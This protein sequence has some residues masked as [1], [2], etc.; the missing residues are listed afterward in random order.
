MQTYSKLLKQG[1][2]ISKLKLG[3]KTINLA[4]LGNINIKTAYLGSQLVIGNT[5]QYYNIKVDL[6]NIDYNLDKYREMRM[7]HENTEAIPFYVRDRFEIVNDTVYL[8]TY[9]LGSHNYILDAVSYDYIDPRGLDGINISKNLYGYNYNCY[10]NK[11][12]IGLYYTDQGR[13]Q[14]G[15]Y[16][17]NAIGF[18]IS[19]S[20]QTY[21]DD[22]ITLT[23][24]ELPMDSQKIR[25]SYTASTEYSITKMSDINQSFVKF[26]YVCEYAYSVDPKDMKPNE[27]SNVTI[28]SMPC[29]GI[30]MKP[31]E[32]EIPSNVSS[33]LLSYVLEVD[34][35]RDFAEINFQDGMSRFI[36]NTFD[37]IWEINNT[38]FTLPIY[39]VHTAYKPGHDLSIIT[40]PIQNYITVYYIVNENYLGG[41]NHD[42][43]D[44]PNHGITGD[45]NWVHTYI[46]PFPGFIKEFYVHLYYNGEQINNS[47]ELLQSERI[48]HGEWGAHQDIA[49][50]ETLYNELYYSGATNVFTATF[51]DSRRQEIHVR[52]TENRMT[53]DGY[54]IGFN[55]E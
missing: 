30:D 14:I 47:N 43:T 40:P 33:K 17:G 26:S 8:Y 9:G 6:R 4:Y 52:I 37:I 44:D 51:E 34:V 49:V 16:G 20:K 31:N 5:E 23:Y 1:Q 54:I 3:N 24:Q 45:I 13:D 29:I 22:G 21:M 53:A 19:C 35:D 55:K 50:S 10:Y 28:E 36:E 18:T 27:E 32:E 48:F 39:H 38:T 42:I 15:C 11:H 46:S 2:K 25:L 41:P 12:G 7:Y